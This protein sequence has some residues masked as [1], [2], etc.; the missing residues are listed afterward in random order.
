MWTLTTR[1]VFGPKDHPTLQIASTIIHYL[2]SEVDKVLFL[3]IKLTFNNSCSVT[4]HP[5][6]G[7][8]TKDFLSENASLGETPCN[9]P[10]GRAS[11][12]PVI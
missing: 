8:I 7:H 10:Q 3:I 9:A 11:K 1:K 6:Q 12:D 4:A 5:K 2:I